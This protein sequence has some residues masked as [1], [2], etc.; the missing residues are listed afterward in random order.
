M[1]SKIEIDLPLISE[2]GWENY[3]VPYGNRK[4][5]R[6]IN[7][8]N[9]SSNIL[10]L[11]NLTGDQMT[12]LASITC[13]IR[14]EVPQNS[15][16]DS[17]AQEDLERDMNEATAE[18][19]VREAASDA[20]R[21]LSKWDRSFWKRQ[22]RTATYTHTSGDWVKMTQNLKEKTL[23]KELEGF[24]GSNTY[25]CEQSDAH[26]VAWLTAVPNCF[27]E[28]KS[29]TA[30]DSHSKLAEQWS[31]ATGMWA[32][33]VR[34]DILKVLHKDILKESEEDVIQILKSYEGFTAALKASETVLSERI[35]TSRLRGSNALPA[36]LS[37]YLER[38]RGFHEEGRLPSYSEI[39][40]AKRSS[41][42]DTTTVDTV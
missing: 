38:A 17:L 30:K 23:Q 1:R 15:N 10:D 37:A 27:K 16:I 29:L 34:H 40:D 18:E 13:D 26:P 42:T 39:Q 9:A 28:N 14:H 2:A 35:D 33:L 21:I 7:G 36:K 8:K 20:S 41:Q 25:S 3:F 24:V 31:Q 22:Y 32:N 4:L 5:R 6:K 11:S 12:V 19:Q